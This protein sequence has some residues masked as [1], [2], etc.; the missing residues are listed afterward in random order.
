MMNAEPVTK[1]IADIGVV[2]SISG[3]ASGATA[4][5]PGGEVFINDITIFSCP[6]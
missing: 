1:V 3:T 6:S 5:P 2:P 4:G